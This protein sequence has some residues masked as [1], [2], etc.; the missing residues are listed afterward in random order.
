EYRIEISGSTVTVTH[1][2]DGADGSDTLTNI[3][4]LEFAGGAETLD[5]TGRI[6][7]FDADGTLKN[8]YD[9]LGDALVAAQDG[10]VIELLAGEFTLVVDE[11]F[12]GIDAAITLRG[13]NAGLPG[14]SSSRGDESL[15]R[16]I[17][18]PLEVLAPNVT[19]DGVSIEGTIRAGSG[20]EGLVISNSRL[21]GGS[22]TALQLSVDG[23]RV[24]GNLVKGK[25]GI[26]ASGFGGLTIADNLFETST[27][28]VRI[29]PG[30]GEERMLV[31]G[32][33]F[34]DGE[35]GVFL[36]GGV[37][38]YEDATIRVHNNVFLSQSDA[39]VYAN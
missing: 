39:A 25:V 1:K 27:V 20:V 7:V 16:I 34:L 31:E 5:L 6:R 30:A 3:E 38:G 23:A 12:P 21:D 22:G 15:M 9:D 24:S 32:N 13:A 29:E 18:G 37:E 36:Q 2:N 10:D 19:I 11:A 28:G 33:T 17:G 26:D 8:I 14:A 4:L 35:Y